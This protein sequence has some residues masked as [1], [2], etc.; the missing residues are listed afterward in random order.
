M[1]ALWA[2]YHVRAV[3]SA[4]NGH[5]QLD[6]VR[7]RRPA[8]SAAPGDG[9]A[10]V[11]HQPLVDRSPPRT[12]GRR[13]IERR[14][15]AATDLPAHERQCRPAERQVPG[16]PADRTVISTGDQ[17]R[18]E[19]P[20]RHAQRR[21]D[22][23]PTLRRNAANSRSL[24]SENACDPSTTR[25]APVALALYCAVAPACGSRPWPLAPRARSG[26]RLR[27][28]DARHREVHLPA[29]AGFLNA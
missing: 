26:R 24:L 10:A 12:A 2:R 13:R 18:V 23:L 25:G 28:R 20:D 19:L 5:P 29:G 15:H 1:L 6:R 16:C 21:P 14:Q 17:R 3:G 11:A 22:R 7:G 4:T 8:H 9:L 27:P